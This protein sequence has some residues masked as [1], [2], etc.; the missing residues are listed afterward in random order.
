MESGKSSRLKEEAQQIEAA[1]SNPERFA[2]LYDKYYKPI[3]IFI[4]KR[5]S[6]KELTADITSK[7]FLKALLNLDKYKFQGFPFSSWLYRI[8]VNEV[9]MHYRKAKKVVEVRITEH[10][11]NLLA[12]EIEEQ[13]DESSQQLLLEAMNEL[14]LEQSQLVELRFF[15][16]YSFK[17]IGEILEITEANAKVRLYRVLDKLKKSITLKRSKTQ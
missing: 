8:A 7:V 15:E 5:V 14:T 1:K 17:E 12:D 3:F 9:N 10:N 4:F 6:D 16:K 2:P 13:P 11:F